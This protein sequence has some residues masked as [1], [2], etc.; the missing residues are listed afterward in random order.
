MTGGQPRLLLVGGAGG[1]VGRALAGPISAN[2]SVRSVHRH[3][4]AAEP[5]AGIEWIPGD[6]ATIDWAPLVR[7]VDV[8]VNLAWYRFGSDR[9]FR[10]LAEGLVRLIRASENA[11]VRRFIQLS[12][13]P[14]PTDLERGL[15]YL[16]WKR[17]VDWTLGESSLSHAVVRASMIFGPRDKLLT[18]MLR[19][20][21]R[22][23][24]F[25]M[26]G[27]G[28]YHVSPVAAADVARIVVREAGRSVSGTID[29]GGPRRWI[30]RELTDRLFSA[31]GRE[32]RYVR[33]SPRGAVRLARLLEAFGS[34]LLYAYEVEWLLSDQLGLPPYSGLD[35]PL[36]EVGPFVEDEARRYRSGPPMS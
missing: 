27:D 35:P 5:G 11:G 25:P 20:V 34:S 23:H 18:V 15:P 31:L 17:H 3:P 32:P 9:R 6:A 24:R 33:L 26:F 29:A 7:D 36:R 14:A 21:A 30:Y 8:V 1:L 19:T 13:P 16:A 28:S 22:Y 2:W 12:V 4:V 10:P